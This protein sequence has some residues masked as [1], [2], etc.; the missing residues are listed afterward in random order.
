MA[1]NNEKG[2]LLEEIVI[3]LHVQDSFKV[4]KNK[5]FKPLNKNK[6]KRE[7]DV[8]LSKIIADTEIYIPIECKN[9]KD[10]I[11]VKE[12]DAYFGKLTYLGLDVN[13]AIFVSVNGYTSG[14]K[15]SASYFGIKLLTFNGLSEDRMSLLLFNAIQSFSY[16]FPIYKTYSIISSIDSHVNSEHLVFYDSSRNKK[17]T[18][19]DIIFEFWMTNKIDST[20]GLQKLKIS[21][22]NELYCLSNNKLEQC[23]SIEFE[24]LIVSCIINFK[25]KMTKKVLLEN[26]NIDKLRIDASFN[27]KEKFSYTFFDNEQSLKNYRDNRNE[28]LKIDFKKVK[29]PK[30]RM[31]RIFYPLSK[32]VVK[33]IDDFLL[34]KDEEKFNQEIEVLEK[35]LFSSMWEV[36]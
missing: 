4:E 28:H 30:V 12:I 1:D 22:A 13:K 14:A 16:I 5:F 32:K 31:H 15:N 35:D 27:E 34:Y 10:K 18:L 9:Y 36:I 29:L 33:E 17:G 25:G 8:L 11:E 19:A 23:F 2:K 20:L 6:K 7:I 26:E 21:N 3:S 24:V